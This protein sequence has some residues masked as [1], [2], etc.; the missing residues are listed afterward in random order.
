MR[1]VYPLIKKTC[2]VCGSEFETKSGHKK[3]KTTCSYSCSNRHFR[4]HRTDEEKRKI[5]SR[6][7][8]G[9]TVYDHVCGCCNLPF[10]S[11]KKI[12]L[13][14]SRKC[15]AHAAWSSPEYVSRMKKLSKDRMDERVRLGVHSGW[16]SRKQ[17]GPSFPEKFFM[18]VLENN[19][20]AYEYER[21]C[22]KYFIDFAIESKTV[23]LE[24]DGKQHELESR[25]ISDKKKDEYLKSCGWRVYRIK[26]K[27]INTPS[28]KLY[29][30]QEITKFLEF[31][32]P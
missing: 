20:I 16:K 25:Q 8:T 28:G 19:G 18:R 21:P 6:M 3:E 5:S 13:Y 31:I 30:E 9:R 7:K 14:C 15:R 32:R 22:G 11:T 26:W 24:I 2:P 12:Q 10:V 23:A 29:I 27:S 1:Q 4:P 17:V